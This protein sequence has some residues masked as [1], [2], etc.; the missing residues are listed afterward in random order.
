MVDFVKREVNEMSIDDRKGVLMYGP[1]K[2]AAIKR[3]QANAQPVG[4]VLDVFKNIG[5]TALSI[6]TR[7]ES[8]SAATAAAQQREQQFNNI[9]K[10]GGIAAVTLVALTILKSGK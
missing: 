5:S 9:L 3:A 4:D 2:W 1:Q 7:A 10:W 6:W 8:A